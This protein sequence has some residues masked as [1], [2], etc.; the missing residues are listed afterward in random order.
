MPPPPPPAPQPGIFAR[1][2][3]RFP[4]VSAAAGRVWARKRTI[5]VSLVLGGAAVQ[6][7]VLRWN[8]FVRDTVWPDTVLV[9][10]V[11]DGAVVEARMPPTLSR[12]LTAPTPGEEPPRVM[13]L[14]EV[15]RT[16][17]WAQKDPRIRGIFAD[18]SSLHIPS[19]TAGARLGLAQTEELA[20][21]LAEFR[22]EK[23]EQFGVKITTVAW[24][25]SFASQGAYM[26]ASAFDRVFVQP[27]GAVP[28]VGLSSQIPFYRRLL[29]W[30][31]IRVH[32]EA[33]SE[34]KSMVSPFVERDALPAAQLKNHAELLGELNYSYAMAVGKN[35]FA[36]LEPARAAAQV[37][38]LAKEG[39]YSAREA[40]GA[41]LIDGVSF[42]RDALRTLAGPFAGDE[43]FKA[44]HHYYDLTTRMLR[45]T[46]SADEIVQVGIVYLLG[47]ISS[48]PGEFSV[49]SAIRGL[50]EA[51][52]DTDIGSIV[53]RIDSGG[54]DVVASESLWDAVR[55]VRTESKKPVVVSFGN[56]AAS[57][58]YYVAT[59]ADAIFASESTITGSI[60]VAALRPTFTRTLFERLH[61]RIQ[62]VFTGSTFMSSL[63]E[64]TEKQIAR[65]Q[66]HIDEAYADFLDKVKSGRGLSS[67]ALAG[68]VGGRVMTGLAALGDRALGDAIP[69]F[70]TDIRQPS[71][72]PI[73]WWPHVL[74]QATT[75]VDD[76]PEAVHEDEYE[77]EYASPGAA[78]EEVYDGQNAPPRAAPA[79]ESTPT[80]RGLVD[81]LGGIVDASHYA[82]TL[83]LQGEINALAE[84]RGISAEEAA[85]QIRPRCRRLTHG[86]SETIVTDIELVRFPKA[87]SL[88]RRVQQYSVS[89]EQPFLALI[90][91]I[92]GAS[93]EVTRAL[94]ELR[95]M[96]HVRSEYPYIPSL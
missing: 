32:A 79:A 30:A 43:Q 89:G 91:L 28:L 45:R 35:R 11:Y 66:A 7:A 22:R 44:L 1:F 86:E 38:A 4:R 64:P 56:I 55:R 48:A 8:E 34:Y 83:S 49:S 50:A 75:V 63:H 13:E 80:S 94:D 57:G 84:A 40:V 78:P 53:L 27:S 36:E 3:R 5:G 96:G 62:S 85:A 54:G 71:R 72:S 76:S 90:P 42:K 88:W 24:T 10:K 33:R 2:A 25:D 93:S 18:F 74:D 23:Q 65:M 60:G 77:D 70:G 21:A 29:D 20:N 19:G 6:Y 81:A 82:M 69:S 51:A 31:G 12:L 61:L 59:A 47:G 68:L 73:E 17:R 9:W 92:F 41:N 16:I 26:L 58:G 37:L 52:K 14:Y 67:E 46:V 87:L 15:L 95:H 39:P